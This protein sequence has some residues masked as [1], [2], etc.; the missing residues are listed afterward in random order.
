MSR[1]RGRA[2]YGAVFMSG[3]PHL[4]AV[5]ATREGLVLLQVDRAVSELRRGRSVLVL[6]GSG[7]ASLVLAAEAVTDPALAELRAAAQSEPRMSIT[8]RR[9]AMLRLASPGLGVVML[10]P[11]EPIGAERVRDLADP[12][13]DLPVPPPF[14]AELT[15]A[16]A[17]PHTGDTAAVKLAKAARL[18]PAAVVAP[19]MD[20][21]AADPAAWAARHDVL[22][23]DAGDVFQYDAVAARSLRPV[24]RARVPLA[25][26]IE[27][28][29]IAFRPRD[30]GLEHLALIIGKV[31]DTE[32]PLTRLHS[33]CFTGDL[34]GSLRCDCGD[35]LR[36]AIAEIAD[37]GASVWI[38]AEATQATFDGSAWVPVAAGVL[39]PFIGLLLNPMIAGA[40]MSMSSV[41]V[42]SNAL[43]LRTVSL[44]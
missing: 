43:R 2:S 4:V 23:V 13:S 39:Y 44:D 33:E 37:A 34:L 41:S 30:G 25:G 18:L 19:V 42:V 32:P 16:A 28:E 14:S 26:A 9:A 17:E 38:E 40:A 12:L 15:V 31:D 3:A 6:D 8:A 1:S 20:A 21:S 22:L 29:I 7:Q 5:P 10:S 35:Q 36:G 27:T 11:R 24:S